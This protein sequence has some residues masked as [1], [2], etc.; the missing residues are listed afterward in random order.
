MSPTLEQD[1][2]RRR[3]R[4]LAQVANLLATA[5][6]TDDP[7]HL[8]LLDAAQALRPEI[9]LEV[10]DLS[11]LLAAA[12]DKFRAFAPVLEV[13]AEHS[14]TVKR[15]EAWMERVRLQ[16]EAGRAAADGTGTDALTTGDAGAA[17]EAWSK[18]AVPE[19]ARTRISV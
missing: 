10:E 3:L 15:A 9:T 13:D 7:D 5:D 6:P 11:R 19:P 8:V 14:E 2:S 17:W 16:A 1:R 12:L 4:A 18:R